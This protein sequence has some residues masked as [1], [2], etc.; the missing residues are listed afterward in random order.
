MVDLKIVSGPFGDRTTILDLNAH[1]AGWL[2]SWDAPAPEMRRSL[3][4]SFL[5]DGSTVAAEV[6]GDREIVLTYAIDESTGD[7]AAALWQTLVRAFSRPQWVEYR[8]GTTVPVF[9]RT[10][11]CSPSRLEEFRLVEPGAKTVTLEIPADPFAY[12]LPE[13][14]SV[15]VPSDPT[16]GG[17]RFTLSGI[18]GDIPA[19][20]RMDVERSVA[21]G[22]GTGRRIVIAS[23]DSGGF[24]DA[25]A[26]PGVAGGPWSTVADAGSIGGQFARFTGDG[27]TSML[28]YA[29]FPDVSAGEYRVFLRARSSSASTS[30]ALA[31]TW[32]VSAPT[33]ELWPTGAYGAPS[34]VGTTWAWIDL[35]VVRL[36]GRARRRSD[37]DDAFTMTAYVKILA[38]SPASGVTADIDHLIAIPV[39]G[40][41]GA[42]GKCLGAQLAGDHSTAVFHL[43]GRAEEIWAGG[44]A[45]G[46]YGWDAVEGGFPCVYPG[47]PT[48]VVLITQCGP[49]GDSRISE[50]AVVDWSYYPRYLYL[51]GD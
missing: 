46:D 27:A 37:F 24:R 14:G 8:G 38:D 9:F 45:Y 7:A 36:P 22:G 26:Y 11:A 4:S 34:V 23:S 29:G 17:M 33:P 51:R 21:G 25:R 10:R 47:S 31:P 5:T 12:G 32:A 1:P 41:D 19:P 48:V 13:S 3:A 20:L 50:S 18:K 40:P 15:T 44:G 35:G 43:D 30:V 42:T 49:T 2:S 16:D 39:P 28:G 6:Y